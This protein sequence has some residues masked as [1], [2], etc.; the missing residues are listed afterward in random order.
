M[1]K[2]KLVINKNGRENSRDLRQRASL[3]LRIKFFILKIFIRKLLACS[4][5]LS[6]CIVDYV[7]LYKL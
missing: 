5:E 1:A 7:M 3:I 2:V 4:V 6:K